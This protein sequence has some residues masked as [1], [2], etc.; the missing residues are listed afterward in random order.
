[1]AFTTI[2]IPSEQGPRRLMFATIAPTENEKQIVVTVL[3]CREDFTPF[4]QIQNTVDPRTE[5]EFHK[6][7]RKDASE[8]GHFRKQYSTNPEWNEEWENLNK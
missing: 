2:E 5:E 8:K 7:L 4:K 3:A 6:Q 1:M